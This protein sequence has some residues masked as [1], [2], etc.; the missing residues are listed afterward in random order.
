MLEILKEEALDRIIG[1]Q[2]DA[3]YSLRPA[4]RNA[5]FEDI[6]RS[7]NFL[8][9]LEAIEQQVVEQERFDLLFCND[10]ESI[11]RLEPDLSRELG[12]LLIKHRVENERVVSTKQTEFREFFQKFGGDEAVIATC[13]YAG[14]LPDEQLREKVDDL[15]E[16]YERDQAEW[17][18]I[19][20]R[21]IWYSVDMLL[22]V[23][24]VFKWIAIML[25]EE[26]L[27]RSAE[28]AYRAAFS[29]ATQKARTVTQ[30]NI[31]YFDFSEDELTELSR[32][33]VENYKRIFLSLPRAELQYIEKLRSGPKLIKEEKPR[34]NT[35]IEPP[36]RFL[37]NDFVCTYA[38][39]DSQVEAVLFPASVR[40]IDR[41]NPNNP[42]WTAN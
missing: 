6:H 10:F 32:H 28:A 20:G 41:L 27:I 34:G 14:D 29:H 37:R 30:T 17:F 33:C 13:L 16:A 11:T 40:L 1:L 12:M 8:R 31:R 5:L 35:E 18:T 19:H 22:P 23:I 39:A 36:S 15:F 2:P 21:R 7:R 42:T 4:V 38:L 25:A 9:D 26:L 3:T 24:D